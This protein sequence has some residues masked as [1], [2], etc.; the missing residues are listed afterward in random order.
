MSRR[1][2]T[3]FALLSDNEEPTTTRSTRKSRVA[4]RILNE[5]FEESNPITQSHRRRMEHC[6]CSKCKGK[7]VDIRTKIVHEIDE[8]LEDDQDSE[9]VQEGTNPLP[10]L[11]DSFNVNS[12]DDY[13]HVIGRMEVEETEEDLPANLSHRRRSKRYANRQ[14]IAEQPEFFTTDEELSSAHS[15]SKDGSGSIPNGLDQTGFE[16]NLI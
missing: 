6:N 16:S 3:A 11:E 1:K 9:V 13:E 10:S 15:E 8:D 5:E 4:S 7:M 12:E 14:T 2:R